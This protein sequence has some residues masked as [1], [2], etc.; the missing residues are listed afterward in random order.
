MT[1]YACRESFACLRCGEKRLSLLEQ[2]LCCLYAPPAT[3]WCAWCGVALT[4]RHYDPKKGKGERVFCCHTC[5]IQYREDVPQQR[6]AQPCEIL[7]LKAV[8]G[9]L[10]LDLRT[11]GA[12]QIRCRISEA[13]ILEALN[14][15]RIE[16]ELKPLGRKVRP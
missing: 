3:G 7:A 4:K 12:E 16:R 8:A 15:F 14:K 13:A 9:S 2:T 5:S 1:A 6:P 11:D 10:Y